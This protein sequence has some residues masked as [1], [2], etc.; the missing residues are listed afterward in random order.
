VIAE[1]VLETYVNVPRWD[2]P[3]LK[4]G[5]MVRGALWLAREIGEGHIFTK[6]QVRR[7]FPGISQIDRRIRDL[8]DYGWVIHT[9]SDDARLRID[10]QRLVKIG[11]PVWDS[12]ARRAAAPKSIS[13]KERQA[14]LAADDYQCVVCGVA[15][16]ES[17][18]DSPS[19]T[20]VLSVSRRTVQ[21]PDGETEDQLVT[22]CKRCRAGVAKDEVVDLDRLLSDIAG[23]DD[24]DQARLL[25]WM[26][27]GR[28]GATPL[29]R[30]W[31][32]YMR[33]PA[34]SRDEVRKKLEG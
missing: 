12:K 1:S 25:R 13:A 10:E 11:V 15:G 8:R 17:Y 2:D 6:E 14:T 31:T 33:L 3:Q 4:A 16:G 34:R 19:D 9:S 32:A 18:P 23:L 29:D 24:T 20:A 26:R 30:A 21:T 22:E 5:A 7:T 28:R 27:R